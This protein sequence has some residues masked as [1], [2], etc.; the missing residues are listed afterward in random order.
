MNLSAPP[1]TDLFF[2]IIAQ[3]LLLG[4]RFFGKKNAHNLAQ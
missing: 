3:F 2:L 4:A 1:D